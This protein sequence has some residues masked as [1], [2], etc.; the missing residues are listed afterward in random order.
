LAAGIDEA[1]FDAAVLRERFTGEAFFAFISN[2]IREKQGVG[3]R[4]QGVGNRG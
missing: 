1:G 2:S 4:E 3:S